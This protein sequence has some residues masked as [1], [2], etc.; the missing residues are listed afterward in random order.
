M[1]MWHCQIN[2]QQ[3]GPVD[4][5]GLRH[6]VQVGQLQPQHLVWC[7]GMANWAPAGTI[8]NLFPNQP[9]PLVPPAQYHTPGYG[10]PYMGQGGKD[11]L[12]TVLLCLF[13]GGLG[14]HRFY[15]GH[16]AIG[17]VQLLTFGGCGIWALVDLIMILTGSF[18]DA[19]G[20]PL[21]RS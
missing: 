11:W 9:P 18:R 5:A 8:A 13:I 6:M 17:I 12:V 7:E 19:N 1:A 20:Q 3:V 10:Q 4:D 14:G 2:G 16:I 15:T 21:I